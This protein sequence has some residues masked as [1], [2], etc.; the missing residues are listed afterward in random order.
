M[1]DRESVLLK[2]LKYFDKK[3]HI[4]VIHHTK[5]NIYISYSFIKQKNS[6]TEIFEGKIRNFKSA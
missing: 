4:V 6:R 1:K 5:N 2:K 3:S